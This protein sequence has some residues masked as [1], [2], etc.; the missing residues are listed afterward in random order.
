MRLKDSIVINASP[1]KVW[2]YVGSPDRWGLFHAK[3]DGCELI[4]GQGGRLGSVYTIGFRMGAKTTPTRCEIV[5]MQP[6][7]MI[8]VRSTDVDPSQP[9]ASATLTYELDDLGSRTRVRER[10]EFFVPGVNV[11]FRVIIW[12]ISRFGRPQGETTL[13]KLK[14]MA[15]EG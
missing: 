4:S 10:V 1:N 13:G 12:L 11:V 2:K 14:R 7:A 3:V 5:D 9:G 15:E 8:Q 6:G